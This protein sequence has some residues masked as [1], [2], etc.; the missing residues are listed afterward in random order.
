MQVKSGN[1]QT[2]GRL[3]LPSTFPSP[4]DCRRR[5]SP[6][7]VAGTCP[8]AERPGH[9]Y[10]DT[11]TRTT[12]SPRKAGRQSTITSPFASCILA[13]CSGNNGCGRPAWS[14]SA[15][16]CFM[17]C[18]HALRSSGSAMA[19][20]G[21]TRV[22]PLASSRPHA[23]CGKSPRAI[24]CFTR[25]RIDP[26]MDPIS[27]RGVRPCLHP[28]V[29]HPELDRKHTGGPVIVHDLVAFAQLDIQGKG[30]IHRMPGNQ[31]MKGPAGQQ[32]RQ[33]TIT[34]CSIIPGMHAYL[35]IRSNRFRTT[36]C[37][38]VHPAQCPI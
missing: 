7:F 22:R 14:I 33:H 2:A 5:M 24:F 38:A 19:S 15:M 10:S 27:R 32:K 30:I 9:P 17:L 28:V 13:I 21:S 23:S 3:A 31:E 8:C 26:R 1:G 16:T 6:C 37:A 35:I 36:A 20:I 25:S 18:Q 4:G 11:Q 12:P 29:A 34:Q